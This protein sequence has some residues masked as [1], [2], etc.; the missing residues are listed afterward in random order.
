MFEG[1]NHHYIITDDNVKIYYCKNF[2]NVEES[3][4][5]LVFN[6]GLICS[7][8]HWK[9]QIPYFAKKY[10]I[11]MHDYRGH[12]NSSSNEN[13]TDVTFENI[14]NDLKQVLDHAKVNKG[15]FLGHSMG[16]NVVL[17]YAK[18]NLSSVAGIIVISGTIFPVTNVMFDSNVSEIV[19][20]ILKVLMDKYPNISNT[21]WGNLK[22]IP[23]VPQI[24]KQGG[25]NVKECP[26]EFI[27]IYLSKISQLPYE[28]FFQLFDQLGTHDIATYLEEM[29]VPALVMG[30]DQDKSIPNYMQDILYDKLPQAQLYIIKDG[31]HVP[32]VDFPD[33]V[34]N[35]IDFFLQR[36]I[37]KS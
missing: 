9:Y 33:M 28:M 36:E 6:Y 4:S 7:N 24:I 21:F 18:R 31:S 8:Y 27:Q 25:F 29:N 34:N 37:F 5:V 20:P 13:I 19:A 16:V 1:F 3:E 11:L 2:D 14:A 23:L 10:K 35:R 26:D 17:E 32:Q 22:F 30:G 12:F 15:I